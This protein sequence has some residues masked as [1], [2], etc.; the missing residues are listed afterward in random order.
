MASDPAKAV[1]L[2]CHGHSRPI[3]HISFSSVLEDEQYYL[4]T[5]CKDSNPMLRD[6]MTGDWVWD[7]HTGECLHTLTHG[8]IVRAV[9]F[10]SQPRP[11]IVAT[12]GFENKLRI[13]DLS[14]SES[15]NGSPTSPNGA[16][17]TNGTASS[18]PTPSYEIGPGVHGGPIKSVIWSTDLNVLIT[19]ADDKMVRWWDLR[20]RSAAAQ[21]QL[22]GPLGTC[23]LDSV[24][25]NPSLSIAAGKSAYFFSGTQPGQLLKKVTTSK[26]IAAVALHAKQRKFVTGGGGDTWVRVYDFD[27]EKEVELQKGHHGPIWTISFSP[28]GKMYATGSEDGTVKL[29]KFCSDSYGL[30]K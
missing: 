12:G 8:H 11:Q 6:G 16:N 20:A 30:W 22:E 13:F 19:A 1:P 14:R 17:G 21:Y 3:T 2:S 10:P 29:W 24:S 9:A 28:D 4:V 15:T 25:S 23:E 5:A 27:D 26:E 7:T 18:N